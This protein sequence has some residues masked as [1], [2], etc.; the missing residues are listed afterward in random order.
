MADISSRLPVTDFADGSTGSATPTE[1]ILVGGTDGTDLRAL[2]TNSSG[3]LNTNLSG[4]TGSGTISALNG[5]V[6]ATTAGYGTTIFNVTGTWVGTL[7]I[8]GTNGDGTWLGLKAYSSLT[9]LYTNVALVGDASIIVN[10]SG[11]TQVR[12]IATAYTSGT[13]SVSWSSQAYVAKQQVYQDTVGALVTSSYTFDGS[14]NAINSVSGS[15][16]IIKPDTSTTGTLGALNAVVNQVTNDVSSAY[17]SISGTW[18]GT[19]QFQGSVDGSTFV[20]LEAVQGGPTNAYTTAG[21]TTNGGVRIAFSAGFIQIQAKMIAYTSGTATIILNTSNAVANVEAIQMNAANLNV[22]SRLQDGS[23]NAIASLNSQLETADIVN[24]S[25]SS[26]SITVGTTSVAARVGASNL[27]NRKQLMISP[28][29]YTIYM[30]ATSGVTTAT[31]IPIYPGQ[32]VAFAY[33]ASVTPYLIA[34][35]SSTVNVFEGA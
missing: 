28:V 19:I 29:T 15:L 27:T 25:I 4:L 24:S 21:F 12:I 32:V 9:G 3:V 1:A 23:G 17:A 34:A 10:D 16:D 11:W 22:T 14:G 26:G 33:G 6:V 8:Q 13:A 31:G 2:S 30:G 7:L 20:P 35:T 18:V 5:T